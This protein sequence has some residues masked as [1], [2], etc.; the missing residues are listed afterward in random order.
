MS[1]RTPKR[2]DRVEDLL[3]AGLA[4]ATLAQAVLVVMMFA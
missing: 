2:A 3:I 4:L 1:Q